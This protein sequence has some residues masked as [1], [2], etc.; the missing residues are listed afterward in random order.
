MSVERGLRLKLGKTANYR[1]SGGKIVRYAFVTLLMMFT[2]L[3]LIYVTVTAFKPDN[4]LFIF[5]P[6]FFVENPTMANFKALIGAFD[7]TSVPFLKYVY[8]SIVTTVF[9]VTL[10]ILFCAMGAYGLSKKKVIMGDLIFALIIAALSFP[11]HVTQIPNY[12]IVEGLGLVDSLPA[13]IIPKIAVGYNFF[14]MKQ[15]CDQIPNTLL[16]AARIDGAKEGRIFFRLVFPM[17]RP[18]WATL[19]VLSFTS[20]WNDYFSP[21]VF[22]TDEA[23]KTLP[24]IMSSIAENGSM[25]RAGASAASTFLM[26]MPTILLFVVMQKQVIETMT[27][28][29][30]KE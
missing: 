7:S 3:P 19:V 4:E 14:L 1:I 9:T 13:L 2:I 27:Y 26:T 15:F 12:M 20:N 21:L 22:I 24:L 28:S 23:K 6:R 18:A 16:E 11:T 17:L 10:T 25:A 8:N 30:I 5:P 29:G